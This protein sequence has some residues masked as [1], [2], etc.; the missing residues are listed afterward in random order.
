MVPEKA[1]IPSSEFIWVRGK[2]NRVKMAVASYIAGEVT[3]HGDG[4]WPFKDFYLDRRT[5]VPW[6][7][8]AREIKD[9]H[10]FQF[11]NKDSQLYLVHGAR[12]VTFANQKKISGY[13][14]LARI[15]AKETYSVPVSSELKEMLKCGGSCAV[16]D[17]IQPHLNGVWVT[18]KG[19]AVLSYAAS[20]YVFYMGKG[21][22]NGGRLAESIPF[23][24]FLINLLTVEG[25]RKISCAGKYVL[26]KFKHGTVWQPISEEMVTKFP[27]DRIKKYAKQ[28]QT[29]PITFSASGRRF[30]RLIVR[31]GYYMQAIRRRDWVVDVKGKRKEE[32]I[33]L[34][35]TIPGVSFS[36]KI[37][38]LENLKRDFRIE[39]PLATLEP[40]FDFLSRHSRKIP[41]TVR[42]NRRQGVSYV[43]AGNY[44]LAVPSKQEIS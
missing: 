24:L 43:Q 41:L 15:Q 40:I 3:L 22:L 39:W 25:L 23:P 37:K 34:Y 18:E 10:R 21:D 13:G 9:K 7:N 19:K 30:S 32:F 26:L 27:I 44:W 2:G 12:K 36:E 29:V 38:V 17:T 5:F 8:A 4:K 28:S 1:G 35:S 16:S 31:M 11:H 33:K 6:V 42:V 14:N 20:D